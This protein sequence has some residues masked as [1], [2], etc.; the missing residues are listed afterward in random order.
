MHPD[1]RPDKGQEQNNKQEWRKKKRQ[2]KKGEGAQTFQKKETK[3]GN[4]IERIQ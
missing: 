3:A 4:Q 2:K 1:T